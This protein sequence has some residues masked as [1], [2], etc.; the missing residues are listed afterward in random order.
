M[1]CMQS[2]SY[3]LNFELKIVAEVEAVKYNPIKNVVDIL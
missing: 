1:L 2:H 3:D